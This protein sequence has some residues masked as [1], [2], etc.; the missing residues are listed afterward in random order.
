MSERRY[1]AT[2]HTN[3]VW[4]SLPKVV[5]QLLKSKKGFREITIKKIY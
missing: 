1:F 2:Q 5:K 3:Q 4:K